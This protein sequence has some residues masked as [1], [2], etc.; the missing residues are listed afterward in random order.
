MMA[1]GLEKAVKKGKKT[2][3]SH[4]VYPGLSSHPAHEWMKD[5]AFC[6]SFFVIVFEE[7]YRKT[8]MYQRFLKLVIGEARKLGV[9]LVAGSSFG[10]SSTRVY[11]TA[12]HSTGTTEPFVRVSVGTETVW[13]V[14][15]LV[16]ALGRAGERLG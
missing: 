8:R 11:L 16:M 4:V 15:K 14:E 9:D 1:E 10:F 3:I 13:E 5:R 6:G 7:K 2:A 12:L